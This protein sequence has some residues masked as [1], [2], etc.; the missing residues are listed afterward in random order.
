MRQNV[1]PAIWAVAILV[2]LL[3]LGF[4]GWRSF[5]SGGGEMDAS[6]IAAHQAAKK[7]HDAGH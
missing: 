3:V 7:A 5:G 6:T 2:A 1:T 4:I